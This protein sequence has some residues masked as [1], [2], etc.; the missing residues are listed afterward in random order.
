MA[1]K[2]K[3]HSTKSPLM[4]DWVF[5][6]GNRPTQEHLHFVSYAILCHHT[7][8]LS[9]INQEQTRN[10]QNESMCTVVYFG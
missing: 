5:R 3:S 4:P 6:L 7:S 9:D 10:A 1:Q 8:V 2:Q